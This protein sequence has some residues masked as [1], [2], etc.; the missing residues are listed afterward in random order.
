MPISLYIGSLCPACHGA[1]SL[2]C[3]LLLPNMPV[4]GVCFTKDTLM[5]YEHTC[6]HVMSLTD[7]GSASDHHSAGRY[8]CTG[9]IIGTH[10]LVPVRATIDIVPP[11]SC[12]WS[13][14]ST[15]G[16]PE[17]VPARITNSSL[18]VSSLSQKSS[19]SITYVAADD[20]DTQGGESL[21]LL[22]CESNASPR[23]SSGT[24]SSMSS[25]TISSMSSASMR[26]P[27]FATEA[28]CRLG[29]SLAVSLSCL[30]IFAS[31]DKP[32]DLVCK[33]LSPRAC[34]GNRVVERV[35]ASFELPLLNILLIMA[36]RSPR[37]LS[38]QELPITIMAGSA[39]TRFRGSLS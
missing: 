28:R 37:C 25:G 1:G 14:E 5:R 34:S 30:L 26:K 24:M 32:L 22:P 19:K 4:M 21:R 10:A 11:C 17:E 12:S 20:L 27:R 16:A 3:Q 7:P 2:D 35:L 8:L 29:E 39:L 36:R 31:Q 23:R 9:D 18:V 13:D 15:L 33:T 6:A 38:M